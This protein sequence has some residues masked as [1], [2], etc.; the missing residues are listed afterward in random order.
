MKKVGA[1]GTNMVV[2]IEEVDDRFSDHFYPA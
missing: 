1:E 2:V